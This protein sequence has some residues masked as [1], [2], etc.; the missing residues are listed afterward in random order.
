M[1]GAIL[2]VDDDPDMRELLR[3]YVAGAGY[4]VHLAPD[5]LAAS[6]MLLKVTPDL[7]ICDVHM[8]YVD[9]FE[10]VATLRTDATLANIPVIFLTCE[11][12]GHC[13]AGS[14][15]AVGYITKPVRRERLLSLLQAHLP[16][17]KYAAG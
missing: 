4:E 12:E 16:R 7:L 8:P 9:G 14:L 5:A 13:R 6:H 3:A 11:E 17:Q 10:F 1:V 2:I 15:H